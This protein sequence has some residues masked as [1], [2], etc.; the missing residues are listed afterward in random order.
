MTDNMA[1]PYCNVER[2]AVRQLPKT[3]GL[4]VD[5]FQLECYLDVNKPESEME[6]FNALQRQVNNVH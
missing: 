6:G 3:H 2:V 5:S 4:K 1:E